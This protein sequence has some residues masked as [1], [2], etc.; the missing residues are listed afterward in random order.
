LSEGGFVLDIP[1]VVL[2][3]ASI[4]LSGWFLLRLDRPDVRSTI[5]A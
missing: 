5:V 4:L 1:Y 2:G 3:V